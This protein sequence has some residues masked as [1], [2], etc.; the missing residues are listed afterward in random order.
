M[1]QQGQGKGQGQDQGGPGVR[2]GEGP[3]LL[4]LLR[5]ERVCDK[6][7]GRGSAPDAPRRRRGR[8]GGAACGA[9]AGRVHVCEAALSRRVLPGADRAKARAGPCTPTRRRRGAGLAPL[10]LLPVPSPC[11]ALYVRHKQGR[12]RGRLFRGA[13]CA[14]SQPSWSTQ[15]RE[16][17]SAWVSKLAQCTSVGSGY[18]CVRCSPWGWSRPSKGSWVGRARF[19]GARATERRRAASP[20]AM[21]THP[22]RPRGR[23]CSTPQQAAA[24]G[25]LAHRCR[26]GP[27]QSEG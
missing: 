14:P 23:R 10:C 11:P 15:E 20:L 19:G 12:G 21:A 16:A 7:T 26:A 4:G 6:C 24:C 18:R 9:K 5:L 1:R 8:G 27:G 3:R 13:L 2:A 25:G 22:Q 17:S